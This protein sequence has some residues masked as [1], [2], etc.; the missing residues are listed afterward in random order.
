MKFIDLISFLRDF[1]GISN[2][3]LKFK[4]LKHQDIEVL[5]PFIKRCCVND[6]N[7]EDISHGNIIGVYDKNG[8]IVYYHNPHIK[9]IVEDICDEE[10]DEEK[11]FKLEID[12]NILSKDELLKLRSNLRKDG[13]L[14]DAFKVTKQIRKVKAKEPK[15]Y[16]KK[17]EKLLIKERYYD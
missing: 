14:D 1:Y 7:L 15:E 11:E 9:E 17:K 13:H 16:Y 3:S 4:K 8:M 2:P 6:V 10:F 12:L 5:F